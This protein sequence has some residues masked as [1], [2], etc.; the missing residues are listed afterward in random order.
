MAS[1]DPATP[2]SRPAI[3]QAGGPGIPHRE[4]LEKA[5]TSAGEWTRY[6][7]PKALGVLVLLGL[8]VKDL[9]DHADRFV[10]PHEPAT[11]KC[12]LISVTGHT[13]AGLGA[14]TLFIVACVLAAVVVGFV[15]HALFSRL[16]LKGLLGLENDEVLPRS[17]FF[18]GEV[19]R[20][21]S[22]EAYAQD[23]LARKE[24][25]LLRDIAGQVYEVSKICQI[26]HMAS[27][28]AYF[29]LGAFL[30]AWAAAR[31]L[32]SQVA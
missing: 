30:I 7:D 16:T 31:I 13:C 3:A 8:G 21:G 14:T 19:S 23:V 12:E 25:E 22:Q 20:Y 9:I 1:S 24:Y 4:F 2:D 11:A 28:R 15:T 32:L 27:Q 17:R 10:H 18:F 26:K 6:A 5:L 29:A